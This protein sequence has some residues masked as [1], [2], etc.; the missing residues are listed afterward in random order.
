MS[1]CH[2]QHEE[3]SNTCES[4]SLKILLCGFF[5][6]VDRRWVQ[7]AAHGTAKGTTQCRQARSVEAWPRDSAGA[8][9]IL[10]NR[11]ADTV[12]HGLQQNTA[13]GTRLW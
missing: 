3:L 12:G 11:K 13:H 8:L 4:N 5:A 1:C 6:T 9:L 2:D 10:K 7:S